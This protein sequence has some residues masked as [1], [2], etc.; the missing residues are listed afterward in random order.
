MEK[1]EINIT[2]LEGLKGWL[3]FKVLD[4]NGRVKQQGEIK[5]I[6]TNVG[7]AAAAG[8]LNGQVTNFFDYVELGTDAT[9]A[10]ATQTA[11]LAA[12][13]T[14][15]GDR[16]LATAS[17]VTTTVTNDTARWVATWTFSAGF[18]IREVGIFDAA[19]AGNMLNRQVVNITV[20]STDVLQITWNVQVA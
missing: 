17:R 20:V 13:T 18:T 19:S 10:A 6:I 4:K 7:L 8:L 16:K 5:N 2:K 1:K 14:G 12:I 9:A 3:E 11:L 15:G